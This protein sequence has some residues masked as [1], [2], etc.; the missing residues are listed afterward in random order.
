V[1]RD[2]PALRRGEEFDNFTGRCPFPEVERLHWSALATVVLVPRRY[3]RA[4]QT[5]QRLAEAAALDHVLG[6]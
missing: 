3:A 5:P 6:R 1:Q 4:S 2:H